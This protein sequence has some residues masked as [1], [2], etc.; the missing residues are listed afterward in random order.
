VLA[1]LAA[2]QDSPIWVDLGSAS[3]AMFRVFP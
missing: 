3:V 2:G 1:V